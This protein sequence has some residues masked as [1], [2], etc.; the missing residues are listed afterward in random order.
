MTPPTS[1]KTAMPRAGAGCVTNCVI[2]ANTQKPCSLVQQVGPYIALE[3]QLAFLLEDSSGVCGYVC[4][5]LDSAK[6]YKRFH[7]E[8][9]PPLQKQFPKPSGDAS[10]WTAD[11]QMYAVYHNCHTFFPD[12]FKVIFRRI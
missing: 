9:L 5:A 1:T 4:G 12:K 10:K 8:W 2:C 7:T 6:F 3:T 11:E